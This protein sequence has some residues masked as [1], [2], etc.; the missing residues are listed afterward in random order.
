MDPLSAAPAKQRF[1]ERRKEIW[2]DLL[3]LFACVAWLPWVLVKRPEAVSLWA[4]MLAIPLISL[5]AIVA[6]RFDFLPRQRRIAIALTDVFLLVLITWNLGSQTSPVL[7]FFVI[8][9]VATTMVSEPYVGLVVTLALAVCYGAVLL[10]EAEGIIA[11]APMARPGLGPNETSGGRAFAFISVTMAVFTAYAFLSWARRRLERSAERER[12]LRLAEQAAQR[13][14]LELQRQL[15]MAQRMESLGRLAGG[16]AHDFN[17]LLTVIHGAFAFGLQEAGG[18]TDLKEALDDGR[19]ASRRAANLVQQLLA[20]SRRQPTRPQV[21]DPTEHLTSTRR[22]LQRVLSETIRLEVDLEQG[23]WPVK[24]DPTQ[25]EQVL[26][27]L[28]VN[29]RDA[30]PK[31]GSLFLTGRNV[32]LSRADCESRPGLAPGP[33]AQLAVRDTGHGMDEETLRRA[34]EP[35]FTTKPQGRGTGLGL[36]TAFGIAQQ[37]G[38]WLDLTSRTKE[39]TT[40]R[41]LLPRATGEV[42]RLEP[43]PDAK[44]QGRETLLLVE[45]EETL[46]K[47]ARRALEQRG[48]TVLEAG[49]GEQALEVAGAFDRDIDGLVTDLVMPGITGRV[50]AERLRQKRPTLK[51]LYVSGHSPDALAP[52]SLVAEGAEFLPKPFEPDQLAATVRRLLDQPMPG[53]VPVAAALTAEGRS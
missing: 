19:S 2:A 46:R 41:L 43:E 29:A 47:M 5:F 34:F 10:L 40:A 20:F 38:G 28:A 45:D 35:F 17:N 37:N 30:M 11:T 8:A 26:I 39:G 51:V 3:R 49:S 21:I 6:A 15:E 31:G 9:V 53:S 48:Y 23:L 22:M 27:N 25:L 24:I 4:P 16:V 36:S 52:G 7:L 33:Y 50:L 44:S 32:E 13:R 42:V 18:N 12:E 14:A 1:L